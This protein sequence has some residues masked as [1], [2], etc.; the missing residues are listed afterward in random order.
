MRNIRAS[1]GSREGRSISICSNRSS[2]R[3]ISYL[4]VFMRTVSLSGTQQ[5]CCTLVC[6][7]KICSP[8]SVYLPISLTLPTACP[9]DWN[10]EQRDKTEGQ[11]STTAEIQV[12]KLSCLQKPT[13]ATAALK[14]S[15]NK[16]CFC[17]VGFIFPFSPNQSTGSQSRI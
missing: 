14:T 13:A 4:V 6:E 3:K 11:Y 2:S 15:G 9:A 7:N 16:E 8:Q 10:S 17:T 1:L 12:E 5:K